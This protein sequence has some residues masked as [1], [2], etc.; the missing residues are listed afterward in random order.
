MSKHVNY[1][2]C[3]QCGDDLLLSKKSR[4]KKKV[5]PPLTTSE[6]FEWTKLT[7]GNLWNK[8]SYEAKLG[9]NFD[10]NLTYDNETIPDQLC[11]KS[12]SILRSFCRR[13][14][15]Q[16]RG[17]QYDFNSE[18]E[19]AFMVED[20]TGLFPISKGVGNRSTFPDKIFHLGMENMSEE[21][22]LEASSHLHHALLCFKTIYGAVHEDIAA[23]SRILGRILFLT[24]KTDCALLLQTQTIIMME[25]LKGIDCCELVEDFMYIGVYYFA[26]GDSDKSLAALYRS[27]YIL[28]TSFP[29]KIDHPL[30]GIIEMSLG[31]VLRYL[32]EYSSAKVYLSN[33]Y[34]ILCPLGGHNKMKAALCLRAISSIY[35]LERD[36]ENAIIEETRARSLFLEMVSDNHWAVQKTTE[37]IERLKSLLKEK[38]E[39]MSGITGRNSSADKDLKVGLEVLVAAVSLNKRQP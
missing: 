30:S 26:A 29:G 1:F 19:E 2:C 3:G 7:K 4:R 32:R 18:D 8:I 24:G 34:Q 10:L 14:G 12:Y 35:S 22:L 16:L 20:I 23:C 37:T 27:R 6:D 21:R 28:E 31:V 25:R 33:A 11:L 39:G 15:I 9:Y 13:N 17:R 38:K 5:L 36:Y